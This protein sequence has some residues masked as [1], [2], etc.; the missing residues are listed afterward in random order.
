[1]PSRTEGFGLTAL[2]ALSAGLP[3]LVSGNSGL[4]EALKEVPLGSQC[5]VDSEDPKD[6][7]K[8]IKTVRHKRREVRLAESKI[9]CEKYLEKYNW[10][11]PCSL[12][13]EKMQNLAFG[14]IILIEIFLL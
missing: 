14:K 1:M 3:I 13:V 5:I 7:A 12:L 10:E 2:E 9:L 11:K 8:E 6:W 4:G